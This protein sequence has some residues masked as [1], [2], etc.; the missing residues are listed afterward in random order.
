MQNLSEHPLDFSGPSHKQIFTTP[1]FKKVDTADELSEVYR[2]R[3]KV[4]CEEK[5]FERPED[6]PGGVEFDD[7]DKSSRHFIATNGARQA[8]ATARL[9]LGSEKGFPAKKNCRIEKDLS[10]L[11]HSRLGEISRLAVSKECLRRREGARLLLGLNGMED[12]KPP[13]L[14]DKMSRRTIV[15]GLYKLIYIESKMMGL[16]HWLAVMA[17][18]LHQ[19][20][21][22]N[23]FVFTPIGPPVDYHGLRTPYLGSIE[24]IEDAVAKIDP[25]FFNETREELK[26]HVRYHLAG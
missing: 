12:M 1:G 5:G 2:L 14:N 9:I 15:F 11:D 22:K 6:H 7:F 16:T 25:E 19:L 8:I 13:V 4:Y 17:D 10:S 18:G 3:Y 21:K 23:G 26:L 20:L 24:E